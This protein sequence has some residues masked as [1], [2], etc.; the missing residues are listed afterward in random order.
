MWNSII[1]NNI[2]K[3]LLELTRPSI[4]SKCSGHSMEIIRDVFHEDV[5]M[6][7]GRR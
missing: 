4:N 7:S 2:L 6:L 3:A 1:N 5:L